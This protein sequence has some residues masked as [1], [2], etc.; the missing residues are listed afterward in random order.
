MTPM[1]T[2]NATDE[3]LLKVAQAFPAAARI[4]GE[5]GAKLRNPNTELR[6]LAVVIKRDT[7]LAARIIRAANS[8]VF[9]PAESVSSIEQ[10]AS[11]MG[12]QDVH[13]LV[14]AVAAEQIGP[15]T[16]PGYGCSG[17]RVREN[18]L[19]VA[20]LMEEL[21]VAAQEEPREAYTIG[22][23]RSLGKLA[24]AKLAENVPGF[25]PLDPAAPGG[26]PAWEQ[27]MFGRSS[28]AATAMILTA[29]HFPHEIPKAIAEHYTP[30]GRNLPYTQLLHLA[31][32]LAD[33]LGYGLPG[34]TSLW[35]DT[36][37]VYA[38]SGLDPR[39]MKRHIDRAFVTFDRL[40]KAV[41]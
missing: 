16:V 14:G 30:K 7:S 5:L 11:L 3:E 26:L 34:E 28:A 31:A 8:V 32:R 6:D 37:E 35:T 15:A 36:D 4:L 1:P 10:A 25:T 38:K 19:L 22:L 9:S 2:L 41:R 20:L 17:E 24:L 33:Q 39:H 13:R 21:A 29:W 40:S 23:L 12:L 18:S 27:A